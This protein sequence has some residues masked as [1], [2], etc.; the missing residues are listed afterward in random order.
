MDLEAL[1]G[2]LVEG[3]GLEL[4]EA[5]F[6]R[7]GGR[8]ILRVTVDREGGIDLDTIAEASE[9]VSRR[10]DLE[11]FGGGPYTL[12]VSSP[13]LERPLRNPAQFARQVGERV[14]VRTMDLIDGSRT[15]L[16]TLVAAGDDDV[17][18]E[19]DEGARTLRYADIAS[20]RTV[21]EWGPKDKKDRSRR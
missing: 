17:T 16:G 14:K 20:A 12:E 18:I 19:T 5:G 6:A 8:R 2:P 13:G 21:F 9:K 11:D 10:L 15:H 3:M 7:E 1:L 4:V